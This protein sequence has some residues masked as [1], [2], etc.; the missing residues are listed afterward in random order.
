MAVYD[1]YM[2]RL[3]SITLFGHYIHIRSCIREYKEYSMYI[4]RSEDSKT[5]LLETRNVS[6]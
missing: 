2:H 6:C 4:V 3:C 1:T 5:S